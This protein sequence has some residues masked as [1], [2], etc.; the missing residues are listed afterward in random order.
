MSAIT[1]VLLECENA[2][3]G[4]EKGNLTFGSQEMG[5]WSAPIECPQ[6]SSITGMRVSKPIFGSELMSI[7]V[8]CEGGEAGLWSR[9][10]TCV[11]RQMLYPWIHC[12]DGHAV[13]GIRTWDGHA[14]K[15][16]IYMYDM[17]IYCCPK[18][19]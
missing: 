13:C 7:E 17:N 2:V 6:G 5:N 16:T 4:A 8:W 19:I 9:D 10:N 1:G 3:T 18:F 14:A 15:K 11:E 12:Q